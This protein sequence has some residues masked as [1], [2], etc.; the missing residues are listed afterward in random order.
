M[1]IK[2]T[3]TEYFLKL[4]NISR[5]GGFSSWRY[6]PTGVWTP[7]L[8]NLRECHRGYHV[9]RPHQVKEWW[10]SAFTFSHYNDS[11]GIWLVEAETHGAIYGMTKTVVRRVRLIRR[12]QP[13]RATWR[14][15]NNYGNLGWSGTDDNLRELLRH[16]EIQVY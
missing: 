5:T 4:L 12:L 11:A 14:G 2:T 10:R 16:N 1:S 7:R 9:L 8:G 13:H 3:K 15:L 6:P